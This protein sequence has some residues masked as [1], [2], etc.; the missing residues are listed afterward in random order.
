VLVHQDRLGAIPGWC[1]ASSPGPDLRRRFD[2]ACLD[3]AYRPR[4]NRAT[5]V[6]AAGPRTEPDK[7][8][9]PPRPTSCSTAP[10]NCWDLAIWLGPPAE[11]S[12][13]LYSF[14]GSR[15]GHSAGGE[16]LPFPT[17]RLPSSS[18]WVARLDESSSGE[19][20]AY[21]CLR[22]ATCR[23]RSHLFLFTLRRNPSRLSPSALALFG[24]RTRT[25]A[26]RQKSADAAHTPRWLCHTTQKL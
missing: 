25:A 7:C 2:P 3:A 15:L 24:P 19:R 18:R 23:H 13:V 16:V 20:A 6:A 4:W 1:G 8:L 26:R 22:V 12:E 11:E 9:S 17:L 10:P 14:G 5:H 21:I